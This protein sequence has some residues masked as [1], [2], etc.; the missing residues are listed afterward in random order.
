M[1]YTFN[2]RDSY[3]TV[4]SI[5]ASVFV[6]YWIYTLS[7]Q[8]SSR[9]KFEN[10]KKITNALFDLWLG[11]NVILADAKK[12]TID[13]T[14]FTNKTYYE[15][16]AWLYSIIGNYG[17]EFMLW[18]SDENNNTLFWLVPF[19]RIHYIRPNWDWA[20]NKRTIVCNFK[21]MKYYKNFQSPFKEIYP[22]YKSKTYDPNNDPP[23]LEY[24]RFK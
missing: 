20:N 12:Y 24:T 16:W 15:Q 17:I 9:D 11:R 5:V 10:E 6:A 22:M 21:W 2:F 4:I 7:K 13:R 3:F 1:D 23:F 8:L 18:W 14:D 19:E